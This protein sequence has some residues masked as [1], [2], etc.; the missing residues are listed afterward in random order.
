MPSIALDEAAHNPSPASRTQ[1][2]QSFPVAKPML[3]PPMPRTM[4]R[5]LAAMKPHWMTVRDNPTIPSTQPTSCGMAHH[6]LHSLVPLALSHSLMRCVLSN[7][8]LVRLD[9][10]QWSV[11]R[12]PRLVRFGQN[13]I[14]LGGCRQVQPLCLPQHQLCLLSPHC[15]CAVQRA[16]DAQPEDDETYCAR[17]QQQN[18]G[19]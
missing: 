4:G 8:S 6:A 12:N 7:E 14:S 5:G 11:L 17:M 9:F 15:K 2:T 18:G 19:E 3:A 16:P 13:P 10:R 1:H